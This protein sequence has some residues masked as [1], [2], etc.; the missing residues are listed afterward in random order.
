VR[1][2][3]DAEPADTDTSDDRLETRLSRLLDRFWTLGR[4]EAAQKAE[5]DPDG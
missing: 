2:D 1:E 5:D 3:G 4:V